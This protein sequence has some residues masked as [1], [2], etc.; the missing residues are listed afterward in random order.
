[1]AIKLGKK[2]DH[3]VTKWWC[4][5]PPFWEHYCYLLTHATTIIVYFDFLWFFDYYFTDLSADEIFKVN[6]YISFFTLKCFGNGG[7]HDASCTHNQYYS[8]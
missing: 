8:V 3:H 5:N 6:L 2:Y 7:T 4:K 1:M